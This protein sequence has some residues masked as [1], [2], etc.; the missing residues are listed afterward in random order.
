MQTQI[1]YEYSLGK[2]RAEE[3]EL[4]YKKI[5]DKEHL[6]EEDQKYLRI[7]NKNYFNLNG[8]YLFN[9]K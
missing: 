4:E 6:S 2:M 9:A 7:I 1:S 8:K 3:L 5:M